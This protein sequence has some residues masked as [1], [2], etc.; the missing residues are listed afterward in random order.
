MNEK[1]LGWRWSTRDMWELAGTS[2]TAD[3]IALTTVITTVSVFALIKNSYYFPL[4]RN[5][6]Y[7]FIQ[8]ALEKRG[9]NGTPQLFDVTEEPTIL[10][11][12]NCRREPDLK[13]KDRRVGTGKNDE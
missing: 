4:S 13:R 5:I 6:S 9:A 10:G 12:Q 2:G 8:D 3:L 7:R 1:A 11:T